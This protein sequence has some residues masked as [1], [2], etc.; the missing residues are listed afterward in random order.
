MFLIMHCIQIKKLH[1]K[2]SFKVE[3]EYKFSYVPIR[4]ENNRPFRYNSLSNPV[5]KLLTEFFK[6]IVMSCQIKYKRSP[7][8]M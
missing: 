8:P 4:R 5:Y 6:S 2:H 1:S 3:V 7:D